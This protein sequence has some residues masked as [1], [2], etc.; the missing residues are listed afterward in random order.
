MPG[1]AAT[2]VLD[3]TAW[4]DPPSL[5]DESELSTSAFD[6]S[7]ASHVDEDDGEMELSSSLPLST[8]SATDSD[9]DRT[10]LFPR[11]SSGAPVAVDQ[12]QLSHLTERQQ[13]AYL[14][15]TAQQQRRTPSSTTKQQQQQ[16]KRASSPTP[17]PPPPHTKPKQHPTNTATTNAPK[18][19]ILTH[20]KK[21]RRTTTTT[22]STTTTTP[23]I[24]PDDSHLYTVQRLPQPN[25]AP[26]PLPQHPSTPA[27]AATSSAAGIVSAH[28]Q[29]CTTTHMRRRVW[30]CG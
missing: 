2:A 12:P 4:D 19:S 26:I 11:S 3:E 10:P 9:D 7:H 21:R 25:T 23:T 24:D 22:A 13:L 20:D 16:P 15:R 30:L 17:P 14:M 29:A 5:M 8:A 27:G 6:S 28:S 18:P 1:A